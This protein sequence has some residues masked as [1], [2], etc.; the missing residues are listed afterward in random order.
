[1]P[2]TQQF[3]GTDSNLTVSNVFNSTEYATTAMIP[4]PDLRSMLSVDPMTVLGYR[5]TVLVDC[6]TNIAWGSIIQADH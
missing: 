4:K 1:M 3:I 5:F 2:G 6:L